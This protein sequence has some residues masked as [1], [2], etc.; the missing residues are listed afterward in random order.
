FSAVPNTPPLPPK[1]TGVFGLKNISSATSFCKFPKKKFAPL[2]NVT[3]HPKLPSI[4][5]KERSFSK[6]LL[7]GISNP[8][9][10]FGI[11]KFQ[12]FSLAIQCKTFSGNTCWF[13]HNALSPCIRL[14]LCFIGDCFFPFDISRHGHY[15]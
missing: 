10:A 8:P 1:Q 5:A 12:R 14:V 15:E 2:H 4:S 11:H 13:V 9:Y 3:V 6:P 7:S